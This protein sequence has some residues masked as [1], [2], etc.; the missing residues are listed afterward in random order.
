VV[1]LHE[2]DLSRTFAALADPTRRALIARLLNEDAVSVSALAAPFPISLPAVMKHLDHL[3][4]AGLVSRSKQGRVVTYRLTPLPLEAASD[5]LEQS[6]RFWTGSLDRLEARA[7][8]R[9]PRKRKA[10]AK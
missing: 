9:T 6:R 10:S 1:N 5:W 2:P 7:K 3:T 8:A 4:N